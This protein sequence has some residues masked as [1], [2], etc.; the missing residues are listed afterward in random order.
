MVT[1]AVYWDLNSEPFELPLIILQH[2]AGIRSYTSSLDFAESCVFS[3]QSLS[4]I[5]ATSL[6]INKMHKWYSISRSYGVIL[7]SSFNIV[8]SPALVY[9]TS[10]PV[11]V[12]VRSNN[13]ETNEQ[14]FL[15]E[16][17]SLC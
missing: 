8:I 7:P 10:L 1:A 4:P 12:L 14:I 17:Y 3:K 13:C 2:R 6:H 5:R 11:S 9:S 16:N 15:E